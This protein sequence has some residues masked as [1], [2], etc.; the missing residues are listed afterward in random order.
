MFVQLQG[1]YFVVCGACAR[2]D[3]LSACEGGERAARLAHVSVSGVLA[4]NACIDLWGV[5]AA[6][7]RCPDCIEK[8][9]GTAMIYDAIWN[10]DDLPFEFCNEHWQEFSAWPMYDRDF[11]IFKL[12][13]PDGVTGEAA[14]KIVRD[15][16]R[17]GEQKVFRLRPADDEVAAVLARYAEAHKG[18]VRGIVS[19]A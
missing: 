16:I 5:T 17:R 1:K 14:V 10:T 15:P 12:R 9:S 11:R 4:E 3:M 6:G 18:A 7:W 19:Y 2:L 8:D 13:W